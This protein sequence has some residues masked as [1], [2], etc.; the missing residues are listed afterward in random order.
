MAEV[1]EEDYT[2]GNILTLINCIC[3]LVQ[4]AHYW[5]K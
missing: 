2:Y 5:F 1:L 4:A 3:G